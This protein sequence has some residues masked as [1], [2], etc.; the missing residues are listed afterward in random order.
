[1]ELENSI[2]EGAPLNEKNQAIYFSLWSLT[3]WVVE[4]DIIAR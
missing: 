1:M 4:G 2:D 3:Q